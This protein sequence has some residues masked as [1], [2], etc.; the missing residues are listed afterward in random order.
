MLVRM[1]PSIEEFEITQPIKDILKTIAEMRVCTADCESVDECHEKL[2]KDAERFKEVYK[3]RHRKL[4][5]SS[6]PVYFFSQM[7]RFLGP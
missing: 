6:T 1:A 7:F 5:H 3:N 2:L 4:T